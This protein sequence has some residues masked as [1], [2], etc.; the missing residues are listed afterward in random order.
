[1]ELIL[2]C[3]LTVAIFMVPGTC[4]VIALKLDHFRYLFVV[5]LSLSLFALCLVVSGNLGLTWK[6]FTLIYLGV[7]SI[8]IVVAGSRLFKTGRPALFNEH[9]AWCDL[10]VICALLVSYGTYIFMV[11]PY[12]EIPADYYRHLERIQSMRSDLL[13]SQSNLTALHSGFNGRYWYYLYAM[14]WHLSGATLAQSIYFYSWFNGVLL[15]TALYLFSRALLSQYFP[16]AWLLALLTCLLFVLHQG[17]VSFSFIRYY[18]LSATMICL[19]VYFLAVLVFTR[20][21]EIG[22]PGRYLFTAAFCLSTPLLYHYQEALFTLIMIW[23]LSLYYAVS[24]VWRHHSGGF[25]ALTDRLSQYWQKIENQ[26][27]GLLVFVLLTCSFLAFHVYAYN[28]IARTDIDHSKV[29]SL[30]RLLPF[31]SNLYLLNPSYQFYQTIALWGVVVYAGFFMTFRRFLLNP[32]VMMGMLSPLFT[33]FNP[34]FVDLF[35]RVRDV[36]VLYRFGYMIP[37]HITAACLLGFLLSDWQQHRLKRR[38]LE[39]LALSILIV[40]LF[41]FETRFLHSEYSRIPTLL[42]VEENQSANHW[43][44]LLAFLDTIEE[45]KEIYTDP[46]TGYVVTAYTHHLSIRY[47]FTDT[48]LKPINFEDYDDLPLKPYNG[49]L[50]VVNLRNGGHSDTGSLSKHWPADILTV[51]RYYSQSLLEHIQ[52]NPSYFPQLWASNDIGVYQIHP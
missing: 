22:L 20:Y 28:T 7:V 36:H 45:P 47:K 41:S 18:A 6:Q 40:S 42:K 9:F 35:L 16:H 15:L 24:W 25:F 31:F 33:V 30:Q 19:P 49:G 27:Q 5:A 37:L 21:I 52:D 4:A 3:I 43:R 44:D 34:V 38:C 51:S 8:L 29:I 46:V 26:R 11:G 14:T 48:F 50:L 1:M 12:D 13:N 2:L 39:V 32:Y 23:L 10:A 17:I